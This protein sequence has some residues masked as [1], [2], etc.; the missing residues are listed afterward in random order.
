VKTPIRLAQN[1]DYPGINKP[2]VVTTQVLLKSRK[3]LRLA[4]FFIGS[5]SK[6]SSKALGKYYVR[7][8]IRL[9]YLTTW[10]RNVTIIFLYFSNKSMSHFLIP[11]TLSLTNS[12]SYLVPSLTMQTVLFKFTQIIRRKP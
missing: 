6:K 9:T 4:D 11:K 8:L 10:L 5:I 7:V 3:L 12:S 2:L 1:H